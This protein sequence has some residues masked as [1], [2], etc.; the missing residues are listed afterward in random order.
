V[1]ETPLE[2][3]IPFEDDKQERQEQK[4]NQE[5]PPAVCWELKA[6][7]VVYEFRVREF[8]VKDE[9]PAGGRALLFVSTSIVASGA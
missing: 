7:G 9:N 8:R 3:Q 4:Q 6:K 5:K 1:A 2:K